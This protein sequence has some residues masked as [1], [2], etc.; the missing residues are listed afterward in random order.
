M[1]HRNRRDFHLPDTGGLP[2]RQRCKAEDGDIPIGNPCKIGP[3]LI[4]EEVG[5]QSLQHL[6]DPVDRNARPR[7]SN[8]IVRQEGKSLDMIQVKMADNDTVN[9]QLPFEG[10][11]GGNRPRLEQDLI[12]HQKADGLGRRSLRSVTTEHLNFHGELHQVRLQN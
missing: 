1:I 4:I 3:D 8:E 5:F 9:G 11:N 10:Q 12:L 6:I 2:L 7:L